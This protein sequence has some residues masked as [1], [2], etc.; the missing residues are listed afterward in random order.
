MDPRQG[1]LP[2]RLAFFRG[3]LPGSTGRTLE[4]TYR[5]PGREVRQRRIRDRGMSKGRVPTGK[6][7][8]CRPDIVLVPR[9]GS[10]VLAAPAASRYPKRERSLTHTHRHHERIEATTEGARTWGIVPFPLLSFPSAA[11]SF[12]SLA[13][14]LPFLAR[15]ACDRATNRSFPGCWGAIRGPTGSFSFGLGDRTLRTCWSLVSPARDRVTSPARYERR[16]RRHHRC[17][18]CRPEIGDVLASDARR[19]PVCAVPSSAA[20][21]PGTGVRGGTIPPG[22]RLGCT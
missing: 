22:Q 17:R 6:I 3:A 7:F 11:S 20:G 18:C 14:L 9:F 12:S 1:Q 21:T 2:F 13:G 15:P 8:D 5:E 4:S 19:V 16:R 10:V